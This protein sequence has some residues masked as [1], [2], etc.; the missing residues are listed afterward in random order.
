MIFLSWFF[1]AL[2]II[3][4][5]VFRH[6]DDKERCVNRLAKLTS[7][8][9]ASIDVGHQTIDRSENINSI[10]LALNSIEPID[11]AGDTR[12][13]ELTI[14]LRNGKNLSGD[15]SRCFDEPDST[16]LSLNRG[17]S[18]EVRMLVKGFVK[19][20]ESVGADL[21]LLGYPKLTDDGKISEQIA[22]TQESS[23]GKNLHTLYSIEKSSAMDNPNKSTGYYIGSIVFFCLALLILVS[24]NSTKLWSQ[25]YGVALDKESREPHWKRI[26]GLVFFILICG[27][28]S[29]SMHEMGS[30]TDTL[31]RRYQS[32]KKQLQDNKCQMT[33]GRL[34]DL[35]YVYGAHGSV[36]PRMLEV[37]GHKFYFSDDYIDRTLSDA[38]SWKD[39]APQQLRLGG[40]VRIWYANIPDWKDQSEHIAK[41][42]VE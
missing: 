13:V 28:V 1:G 6:F 12:G 18:Y 41:L 24:Y 21:P 32:L 14:H 33:T 19:V 3:A 23:D 4:W 30:Q 17:N 8:E 15:L 9:V 35:Q 2:L 37:N 29:Y 10:I 7:G 27:W 16:I 5:Y 20:L 39:L 38:V 36:W 42:D 22:L 11:R 34:T 40:K 25:Y 31:A 26:G